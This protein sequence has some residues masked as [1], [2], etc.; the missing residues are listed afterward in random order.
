L[1]E[2]ISEHGEIFEDSPI[3]GLSPYQL[4]CRQLVAFKLKTIETVAADPRLKEGACTEAMIVY[5]SFL[6]VD[7]ETLKPKPVYAS[8]IKLMARGKMKSKNT[9]KKA[10]QLLSKYQYLVPTGS[11]TKDGCLWYRV[12]N[13]NVERVKM[14]VQEAEAFYTELDAERRREDRRK[15][16]VKTRVV[17][18]TDPTEIGRGINDC[19]HVASENDPKYL[20]GYLRYSFSEGGDNLKR[21]EDP[22]PY[23][24]AAHG[25][26]ANQPFPI[27]E[28]FNESAEMIH[29]ICDGHVVSST[30][31][32][33][34]TRFL[35]TGILTPRM[36]QNLIQPE[37]DAA[38]AAA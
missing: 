12:E 24:S 1:T 19:S 31:R 6:G 37:K 34:L 10:R 14:H 13:P 32:N 25:D 8:T 21:D 16:K 26:E 18:E 22:N 15:R 11:T 28:S 33:L 23:A 2:Y 35:N 20:R 3:A 29:A 30:T 17:S 9:A 7:K 36:A 4:A 38:H 5:L 27:P